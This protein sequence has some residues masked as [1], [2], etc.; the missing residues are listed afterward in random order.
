MMRR[1]I[2]KSALLMAAAGALH[3]PG[4]AAQ[5]AHSFYVLHQRTVSLTA[6]YWNP[7]LTYV[8]RKSGVPLE[9]PRPRLTMDVHP[10]SEPLLDQEEEEMAL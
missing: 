10:P 9:K 3:S 1:T 5:Q 4:A 6:Q 8:G 7:I 2:I